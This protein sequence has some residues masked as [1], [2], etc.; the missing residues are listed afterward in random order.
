MESFPLLPSV[1]LGAFKGG[2]TRHLCSCISSRI[3]GK[4]GKRGREGAS[5]ESLKVKRGFTV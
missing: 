4:E 2:K 5:D 3:E 1:A